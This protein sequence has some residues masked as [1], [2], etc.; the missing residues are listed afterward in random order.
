MSRVVDIFTGKILYLLTFLRGK[1]HFSIQKG[2]SDMDWYQKVSGPNE[3]ICYMLTRVT[4]ALQEVTEQMNLDHAM[5]VTHT[6][7][8]T[9]H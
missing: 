7:S 6:H 4:T 2:L 1:K 9:K 5:S 3:R 8:I